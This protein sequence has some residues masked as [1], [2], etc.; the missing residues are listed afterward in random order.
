MLKKISKNNKIFGVCFKNSSLNSTEK[1]R[2]KNQKIWRWK[3][4]ARF[5]TPLT[6]EVATPLL[7]GV[8]SLV[9][10]STTMLPN[11]MYR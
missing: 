11:I 9:V 8:G 6:T 4:V 10:P 5:P 2:F 1:S 7:L 3:E